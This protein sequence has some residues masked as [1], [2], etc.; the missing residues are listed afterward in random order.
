MKKQK[1][2]LKTIVYKEVLDCII[3]GEFKANQILNEKEL[4]DRFGYS[5]SPIREALIS[6]CNEGVLNN[7]P[8]YGY[9]VVRLTSKEVSQ[10]L[11]YRLILEGGLLRKGYSNITDKQI[12]ELRKLDEL[13]QASVDDMWL[14]WEYNANFHLALLK[15]CENHY[16][17]DQLR[18]SLDILKRAY[19]QFYID[20]WDGEYN[21]SDMKYHN[22]ILECIKNR[23]IEGCIATLELDL[24][25]FRSIS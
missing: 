19:A 21:P 24:A 12:E 16:A 9:E 7:I 3:R 23:D 18:K 17:C 5:K 8:R 4:I 14:H 6:L 13:C 15:T 1:L 25:D 11:E 20:K 10:I 2:S 22:N